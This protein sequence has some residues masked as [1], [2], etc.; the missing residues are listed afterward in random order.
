MVEAPR[1]IK[2]AKGGGERDREGEREG[3]GDRKRSTE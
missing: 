3:E 2:V 1:R